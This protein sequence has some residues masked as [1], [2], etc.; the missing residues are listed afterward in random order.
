MTI[1]RG[2]GGIYF[3]LTCASEG[4]PETLFANI[5]HTRL[6]GDCSA[7]L[8]GTLIDK[9]LNF[10]KYVCKLYVKA[11]RKLNTFCRLLVQFGY[12]LPKVSCGRWLKCIKLMKRY[13]IVLFAIQ[14]YSEGVC[15]FTRTYLITIK[16]Q[17]WSPLLLL[18]NH[19]RHIL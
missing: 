9:E 14:A 1:K 12:N 11:R 17:I 16:C 2:G 19:N 18:I 5:A 13:P 8:F 6:Q 7:K 10:K 4:E 15:K 3:L